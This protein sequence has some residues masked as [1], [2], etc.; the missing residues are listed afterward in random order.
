MVFLTAWWRRVQALKRD[1]APLS[2]LLIRVAVAIAGVVMLAAGV[3]AVFATENSTGSAALVAIGAALI[4]AAGLWDRLESVEF[5]GAKVQLQIIERLRERA[6]EAEVR[7]DQ[8]ADE[9][10]REE[11]RA[12]LAEARPFAA[13]YERLRESLAP[14]PERTGKLEEIFAEARAAA[15]RRRYQ[16]SEV[17][18]LFGTPGRRIFALGLMHEDPRLRD[19]AAA[20][21]AIQHSRSAFEQYHGL[22][23]A[24]LMLPALDED[25]RQK[26]KELLTQR[27]DNAA[28][29]TEGTDRIGVARRILA[30][31]GDA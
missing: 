5:A 24:E 12:L 10:L 30:D 1:V 9:A 27:K 31:L 18:Q 23:I 25:E 7:G 15:R 8:A 6:A 28:Y 22:R 29:I 3:V 26:L 4:V 11:A 13:S 20:M 16:P 19:F 2:P 21:D 14:G 17:L